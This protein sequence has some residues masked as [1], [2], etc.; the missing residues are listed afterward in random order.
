[1]PWFYKLLWK[2]LKRWLS[3]D[4]LSKVAM[5]SNSDLLTTI[6][7]DNLL[8]EYGGTFQF[9]LD[10]WIK[11]RVEIEKVALTG[12]EVG[13]HEID[14]DLRALLDEFS[15]ADVTNGSSLTG[16]LKKRGGWIKI[17]NSR[18]C[19]IKGKVFYYFLDK[20]DKRAEG[21]INLAGALIED[22]QKGEKDDIFHVITATGKDCVF[23][24]K[25]QELKKAWME[26]IRNIK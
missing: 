4:L 22:K 12:P 16:W 11:T 6:T 2:V 14:K 9:N 3:G 25:N 10:K 13:K 24:A 1:M 18:Y 20:N 15:V 21:V 17:Y 23:E 19:V 8:P 26:C 5:L 7:K